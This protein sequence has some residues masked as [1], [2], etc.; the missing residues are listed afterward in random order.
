MDD[1]YVFASGELLSLTS[2]VSV[3]LSKLAGSEELGAP[4][5]ARPWMLAV[6]IVRDLAVQMLGST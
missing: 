3:D 5:F 4:P 6:S 2:G 1:W